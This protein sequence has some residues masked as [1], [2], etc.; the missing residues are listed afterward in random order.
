MFERILPLQFF[1][2]NGWV[3][4]WERGHHLPSRTSFAQ[5]KI[6]DK[7]RT[8]SVGKGFLGIAH[9]FD[10]F[11][12]CN[13]RVF[14]ACMQ[15]GISESFLAA[16]FVGFDGYDNSVFNSVGSEVHFL[17]RFPAFGFHISFVSNGLISIVFVCVCFRTVL[18]KNEKHVE[19]WQSLM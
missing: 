6:S 15:V 3:M 11:W 1:S 2:G 12:I 14:H 13:G 4:E 5:C 16:V 8:N 10:Q 19:H 18:T 9:N 7:K 17:P